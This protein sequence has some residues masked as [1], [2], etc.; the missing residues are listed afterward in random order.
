MRVCRAFVVSR[1]KDGRSVAK[2]WALR[3]GILLSL[4][5]L[6]ISGGAPAAT[7][8]STCPQTNAFFYTTDTQVLA[9][10]LAAN[11]SDCADY[12]ISISPIVAPGP[13]LGEPRGGAALT[14]VDA[15]GPGFHALAELRRCS[16]SLMRRRTAGTRRASSSMTT[17]SPLVTTLP[18]VTRG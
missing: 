15:Q 9:R 1:G 2:L 13:T 14:T 11:R 7:A 12:Y 3:S 10:T 17:C 5:G 18:S 8:D 4:F 6:M 16:G